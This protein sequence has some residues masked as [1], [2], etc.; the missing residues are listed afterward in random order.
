[1]YASPTRRRHDGAR[2][3]SRLPADRAV[4]RQ[5]PGAAPYGR[6][7]AHDEIDG[8]GDDDGAEH[9]GEQALAERQFAE[10]IRLE[11]GVRD[12]EGHPEREREVR[13]V[14]Q[15]R[16]LGAAEL[17]AALGWGVVEL[18]VAQRVDGVHN[19]PGEGDGDHAQ[20]CQQDLFG[21]VALGRLAKHDPD[22]REARDRRR[23][24]E[25][26]R[27]RPGGI[28]AHGGARGGHSVARPDCHPHP[29]RLKVLGGC[30]W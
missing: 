16:R 19:D 18:G 22:R 4:A 9:V 7:G 20:R 1:M 24:D 12:L 13:E 8:G 5:P 3:R 15:A 2:F 14:A 10:A 28:D 11:V 29:G 21:S 27:D 26:I 17:D 6:A 25:Q 23:L 30:G